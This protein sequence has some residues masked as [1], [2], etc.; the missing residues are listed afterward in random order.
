MC[1]PKM[2]HNFSRTLH[3]TSCALWARYEQRKDVFDELAA[4]LEAISV[5]GIIDF[6]NI[7][8]VPKLVEVP[9]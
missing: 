5:K 8:V 4:A 1:I 2:L 3:T 6:R 9:S 7:T